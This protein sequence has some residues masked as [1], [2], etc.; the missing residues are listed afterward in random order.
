MSALASN[1]KVATVANSPVTV[2]VHE[3]LDV[4]SD[5]SAQIPFDFVLCIDDLP[6]AYQLLV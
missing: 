4:L 6:E 3:S 5:L 2:N 1:R